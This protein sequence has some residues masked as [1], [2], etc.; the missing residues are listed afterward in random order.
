[1]DDSC[2]WCASD[3]ETT[4]HLL[5]YCAKARVCW[6][7][8]GLFSLIVDIVTIHHTF[9]DVF[10]ASINSFTGNNWEVWCMTLW[11]LWQS[12]NA[13][14]WENKR[15]HCLGQEPLESKLEGS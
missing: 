4:M 9:G 8:L 2:P 10:Y 1:M 12:R 14:I 13:R 7:N 15:D 11:S 3:S 6:E 5:I